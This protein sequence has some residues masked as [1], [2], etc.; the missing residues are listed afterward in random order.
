[1]LE[2]KKKII[3]FSTFTIAKHKKIETTKNTQQKQ[4]KNHKKAISY[5]QDFYG[6]HELP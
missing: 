2:A 5:L 3:E 6:K 1:M 4:H